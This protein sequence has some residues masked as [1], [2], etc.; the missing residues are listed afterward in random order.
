MPRPRYWYPIQELKSTNNVMMPTCSGQFTRARKRTSIFV[1]PQF[2]IKLI[3][4]VT[5][6]IRMCCYSDIKPT[7]VSVVVADSSSGVNEVSDVSG[8]SVTIRSSR[9]ACELRKLITGGSSAREGESLALQ[10]SK[11]KVNFI[12]R[13]GNLSQFVVSSHFL[14]H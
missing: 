12:V 4:Y 10:A 13:Q 1:L 3:N 5:S 2:T 8:N 7:A 9:S 6:D 14:V 11:T